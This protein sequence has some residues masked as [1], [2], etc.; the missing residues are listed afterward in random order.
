MLCLLGLWQNS[1]GDGKVLWQHQGH[2]KWTRV[3]C[4]LSALVV[5]FYQR[6]VR[7]IKEKS[8]NFLSCLTILR[9]SYTIIVKIFSKHMI[10]VILYFLGKNC[11]FFSKNSFISQNNWSFTETRV[12]GTENNLWKFELD[13]I[14]FLDFTGICSLKYK[15]KR[16]SAAKPFLMNSFVIDVASHWLYFIDIVN[17]SSVNNVT[18][19]TFKIMIVRLFVDII[20]STN[21]YLRWHKVF[22]LPH[23]IYSQ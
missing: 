1:H 12:M 21:A 5:E 4:W 2:W 3:W 11:V 10:T 23:T 13:P 9:K 20:S 14:I 17:A 8:C 16:V 15:V 7:Y 6:I 22:Q 19:K 18:R